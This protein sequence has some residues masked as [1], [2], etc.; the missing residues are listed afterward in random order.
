MVVELAAVV[1]YLTQK[2]GKLIPGDVQGRTGVFPRCFAAVSTIEPTLVCL[3]LNAI[4]DS[5]RAA[6]R[7]LAEVPKLAQRC[8]RPRRATASKTATGSPAPTS[9]WPTS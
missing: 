5:G 2:A 6:Q 8:A 1:L 9:Q 3:D 4:F 7:L